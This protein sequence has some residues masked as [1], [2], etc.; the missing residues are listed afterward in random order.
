MLERL[1]FYEKKMIQSPSTQTP[2]PGV[3]IPKPLV[4]VQWDQ[5]RNFLL[6]RV[7]FVFPYNPKSLSRGINSPKHWLKGLDLFL[8]KSIPQ[9]PDT[10]SRGINTPL[11]RDLVQ[12]DQSPTFPG[13]STGKSIPKQFTSNGGGD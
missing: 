2:S 13:L 9:H 8:K 1:R 6:K 3:S 12:G 11:P 4:L 10:K 7:N 5:S